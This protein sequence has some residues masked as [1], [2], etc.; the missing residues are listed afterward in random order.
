MCMRGKER[1]CQ[2]CGIETRFLGQD[3]HGKYLCPQCRGL[4]PKPEETRRD[5]LRKMWEIDDGVVRHR[6]RSS[7]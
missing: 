6:V 3:E 4:P 2:R 1:Y 7:R 5:R